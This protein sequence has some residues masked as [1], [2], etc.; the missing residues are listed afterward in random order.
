M[1]KDLTISEERLKTARTRV[2]CNY[3]QQCLWFEAP[4]S[5]ST[6]CSNR[7]SLVCQKHCEEVFRGS[8]LG[9]LN[10]ATS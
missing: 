1:A 10:T 7:D 4:S 8:E 6:T 3:A 5:S 9:D 2:S